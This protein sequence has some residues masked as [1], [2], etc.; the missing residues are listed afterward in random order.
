M[1]FR[2]ASIFY[3]SAQYGQKIEVRSDQDSWIEAETQTSRRHVVPFVAE[4]LSSAAIWQFTREYSMD[5]TDALDV[6]K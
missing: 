6:H 4:I 3:A 5:V 1:K 2:T